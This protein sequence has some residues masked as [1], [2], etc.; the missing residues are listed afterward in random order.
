MHVQLLGGFGVEVGGRQVDAGQ[1][2]LRKARTVV[3]L[4]ALE[5]TQRLHREYLLDLLWP[6]LAPPAAAN[7]LHQALHAARRALAGADADGLLELRD[8]VVALRAGGLVE[9]DA[10]RFRA[11]AQAALDGGDLD[12]LCAADTSYPGELLPE[13]PYEPWT[14]GPREELHALHRDVLVRLSDRL[15]AAGRLA[16]AE[17]ALDRA[18]ARDPMHEPA[19]RVL[20]RVLAEQG[21]RSTALLRYERARDD[22][23]S[24]YGTDPDPETRR[25][26]RDLLVGSASTDAAE[27]GDSL[28]ARRHN[29]LPAVT[30]FVGRERELAQV[31]RLL[32]RTQLLTLTGPGGAGKTRLARQTAHG[33]AGTMQDGAWLV[34]LVPVGTGTWS[35]TR[36]PSRWVSRRPPGGIRCA[37]SPSSCPAAGCC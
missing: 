33:A 22:L 9:V 20:L 1:W 6:D 36:W 10:A 16:E 35:R 13:D 15:R 37:R 3:K 28:A 18:L 30:S 31:H 25:L 8:N 14:R 11:Q 19:L 21:R 23:R 34:D 27:P 24:A 7:N 12:G 32:Q 17:A 26:Y 4:L 29:L 2:R 5:P